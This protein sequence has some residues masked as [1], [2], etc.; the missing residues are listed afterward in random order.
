MPEHARH[1]VRVE[2]AIAPRHLTLIER[3]APWR[4]DFGPSRSSVPIRTS[5]L[6]RGHQ[7]VDVV[8]AR[9][10]P[11]LPPLLTWLRPRHMSGTCSP[12][13]TATPLGSSRANPTHPPVTAVA[14]GAGKP[15]SG[16]P[17]PDPIPK[18]NGLDR[19]TGSSQAMQQLLTIGTELVRLGGWQASRP[20]GFLMRHTVRPSSSSS[21]ANVAIIAATAR[22]VGVAVSMPSRKAR[23]R[24]AAHRVRRWYG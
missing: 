5:A 13:S 3:R 18:A 24:F 10:Q 7:V 23:N 20:P 16:M 21:S 8:L 15:S 17:L 1:Q 9:P 12:R 19:L 14:A 22:P 4:E 6:H 11:T 2:C